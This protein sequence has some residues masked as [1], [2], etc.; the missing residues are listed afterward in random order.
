VV[1]S[2]F[3]ESAFAAILGEGNEDK[4]ITFFPKIW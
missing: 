1:D 3:S 4:I 2:D